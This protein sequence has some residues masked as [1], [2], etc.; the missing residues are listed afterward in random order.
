MQELIPACL[1]RLPII[2]QGGHFI[3]EPLL[4][5]PGGKLRGQELNLITVRDH[6]FRRLPRSQRLT[7]RDLARNH[8]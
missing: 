6:R 8:K 7:G 1:I 4:D 5:E 3:R 2:A